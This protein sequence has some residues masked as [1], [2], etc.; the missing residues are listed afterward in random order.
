MIIIFLIKNQK[1]KP[2]KQE[3]FIKFKNLIKY[4]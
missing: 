2:I 4:N 1:Y 3:Y